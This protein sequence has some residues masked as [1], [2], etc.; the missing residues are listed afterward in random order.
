MQRSRGWRSNGNESRHCMSGPRKLLSR[1]QQQGMTRNRNKRRRLGAAEESAK[2]RWRRRSQPQS[3]KR[4]SPR[5]TPKD[6]KL[7]AL[8]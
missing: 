1:W 8:S 7:A 2:E 6:S 5:G 3:S 4:K